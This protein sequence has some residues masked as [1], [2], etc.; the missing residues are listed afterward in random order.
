MPS[1][2][3]SSKLSPQLTQLFER[4]LKVAVATGIAEA[5]KSEFNTMLLDAPQ[6]SG[7]YVANMMIGTSGVDRRDAEF[8]FKRKPSRTEAYS[9]GQLAAV[10]RSQRK[11]EGF[12]PNA[13]AHIQGAGGW[14][15]EI[16]IYN[17]LTYA[18]Y[19][20]AYDSADLRQENQG[21]EYAL[22]KMAERLRSRRI[23]VDLKRIR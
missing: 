11:N 4:D 7:N 2:K 13:V 17:P 3:W 23:G 9:R 5:V 19:V 6:F 1:V 8:P 15:P 21:G 14:L 12:I 10:N 22:E 20:E 18:S 16:T